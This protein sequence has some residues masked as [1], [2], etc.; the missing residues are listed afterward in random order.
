M[1]LKDLV[2]RQA[3]L[4]DYLQREKSRLEREIA[5]L[6]KALL[7]DLQD[8]TVSYRDLEPQLD[9]LEKPILRLILDLCKQFRRPVSYEEILRAFRT[10]YPFLNS[11]KTETVTRRVRRLKEK[12]LLT[13]PQRGYFY[14]NIKKS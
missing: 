12:G 13:S 9:R 4:I 5:L 1:S 8:Q 10:R 6:R 3:R 2:N 7:R 11:V 14:P